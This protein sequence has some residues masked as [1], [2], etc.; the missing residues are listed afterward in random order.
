MA[1]TINGEEHAFTF[2]SGRWVKGETD[3]KGPYLVAGAKGYLEG[4]APFKV[5]GSYAWIDEN[6]LELQLRYIESPHTEI[7]RF[8][9]SEKV[10]VMEFSNS[11]NQTKKQV[12]FRALVNEEV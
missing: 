8:D 10:A 3:R 4:L 7:I 5:A 11:F 9:F 6:T 12:V 1:L 2:G